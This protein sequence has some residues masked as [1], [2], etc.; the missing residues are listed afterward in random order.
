MFV[1]YFIFTLTDCSWCHSKVVFD[2]TNMKDAVW[3]LSK[4]QRRL[5]VYLRRSP[6]AFVPLQTDVF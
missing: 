3:E 2:A 6:V 4:E 1:P 5:E